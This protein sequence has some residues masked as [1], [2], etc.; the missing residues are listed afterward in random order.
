MNG[1]SGLCT[2]SLLLFPFFFV[3]FTFST[4][5][6]EYEWESVSQH[7]YI[8]V[9]TTKW[10]VKRKRAN[11]KSI[12]NPTRTAQDGTNEPWESFLPVDIHAHVHEEKLV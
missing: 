10:N 2:T 12:K 3:V 4:R 8:Y 1:R 11:M 7:L 9:R 5:K 6:S